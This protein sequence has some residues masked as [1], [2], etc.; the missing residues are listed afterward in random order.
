[1]PLPEIVIGPD[2]DQSLD[3]SAVFQNE[4]PVELEIG[5]GKAG[6]LLHRAQAHPELNFLGIEWANKF[7]L[8]AVDRMRRWRITNV[9]MLRT[10]A[11]EF[12]RRVC[13]RDSLAALHVYHPDPWPKTRHHK[14][15]LIQTAFID[16]AAHC[17]MP[18]GRWA[19]QT[20]H[21]EYAEIIRQ[22]VLAHPLLRETAFDDEAFGVENSQVATNYEVKY[23]REGR[24]IYRLAVCRTDG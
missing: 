18:G 13:P 1:M 6:F 20:D 16:A 17:L 7:Y 24:P 14:R 9:R 11:S 8:F 15:R 3:W 22:R 5:T 4:R 12:V 2:F 23:M 10:D 19:I 21:A